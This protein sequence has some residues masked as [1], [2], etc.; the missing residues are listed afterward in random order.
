MSVRKNMRSCVSFLS[1]V[2]S[3]PAPVLGILAPKLSV[4]KSALSRRWPDDAFGASVNCDIFLLEDMPGFLTLVMLFGSGND[5]FGLPRS[6][7]LPIGF[8]GGSRGGQPFTT[9]FLGAM[10]P[11][12]LLFLL[13]LDPPYRIGSESSFLNNKWKL[14]AI[15]FEA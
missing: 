5:S 9:C 10:T 14:F 4:A 12:F 13:L 15:G 8:H 2:L 6:G 7:L 1:A 3:F 11:R